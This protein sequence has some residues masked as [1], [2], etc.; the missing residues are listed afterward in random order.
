MIKKGRQASQKGELHS[1][2]KL[3]NKQVNEIR[4]RLRNGEVQRR[5]AIEYGVS[6]ATISSIYKN[7][8]WKI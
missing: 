6:P 3:S 1:Q 7:K 8:R 4:E 2:N 5:L